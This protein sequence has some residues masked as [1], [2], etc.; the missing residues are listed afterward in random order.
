MF[1]NKLKGDIVNWLVLLTLLFQVALLIILTQR[2]NNL[3]KLLFSGPTPEVMDRIPDEQGHVAGFKDAPITIVEFADFQCP[4]CAA[5]ELIVKRLLLEYPG[6][7]KLIYRHF[8]L[9]AI[10]NYAMQAAEASECAGQ[11][12][13]FWE[14]HDLIFQ[15]QQ[16][17]ARDDFSNEQFFLAAA[18]EIQ[19]NDHEFNNCLSNQIFDDYITKDISDGLRCGISGTPTFFVNEQKMTGVSAI[20]TT[21]LSILD[22]ESE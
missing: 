19:L 15:S 6:K 2:M 5:A 3:E 13:K 4:Y 18:D 7:I 12:G 21:V 8:P 9:T 22:K 14:M 11:Q 16:K 20:E 17:F 10:H 1:I